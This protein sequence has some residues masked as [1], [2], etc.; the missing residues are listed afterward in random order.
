[1]IIEPKKYRVF[2]QATPT[3]FHGDWYANVIEVGA[4]FADSEKDAIEKT[5]YLTQWP[6]VQLA[7]N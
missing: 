1:M 6:L 3:Q 2:K 5:R 4:I 7:R